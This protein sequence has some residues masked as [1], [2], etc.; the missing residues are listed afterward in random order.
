[1][2]TWSTWQHQYTC[3]PDIWYSV[4]IREIFT[5][6]REDIL[7]Y[8][9]TPISLISDILCIGEIFCGQSVIDLLSHVKSHDHS[10]VKN[11]WPEWLSGFPS[12]ALLPFTSPTPGHP[13]T[14]REL[15]QDVARATLSPRGLS[16]HGPLE[17][18]AP[19]PWNKPRKP[20]RAKYLRTCPGEDLLSFSPPPPTPSSQVLIS[21]K[22]YTKLV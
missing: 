13:S 12:P 19:C 11:S 5:G 10:L 20:R 21:C 15:P 3:I 1:M 2:I 22:D 17:T 9:A 14:S 4:Y 7:E 16:H 6:T 8:T 18:S